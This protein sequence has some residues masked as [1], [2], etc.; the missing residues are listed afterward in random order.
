MGAGVGGAREQHAADTMAGDWEHKAVVVGGGEAEGG[1]G[2]GEDQQGAPKHGG[3]AADAG[4]DAVRLAPLFEPL[5]RA[6][7]GGAVPAGAAGGAN[8]AITDLELVKR[9]KERA[10]AL[11]NVYEAE[12]WSLMELLRAEHSR[13]V[14]ESGKTGLASA[15]DGDEAAMAAVVAAAEAAAEAGGGGAV[16][17]QDE[18]REYSRRRRQLIAE[19]RDAQEPGTSGAAAENG[20]QD[21]TKEGATV[22]E[23]ETEKPEGAPQSGGG[24]EADG[25]EREDDDDCG[26]IV[27]FAEVEKMILLGAH[28]RQQVPEDA[29]AANGGSPAPLGERARASPSVLSLGWCDSEATRRRLREAL[30]RAEMATESASVRAAKGALAVILG[31]NRTFPIHDKEVTIGRGTRDSRCDVDLALEDSELAAKLSRHAAVLTYDSKVDQHFLANT[32]R[33]PIFVNGEE[34]AIGARRAL[35]RGCLLELARIPCLF[36][37][38][39]QAARVVQGREA[40][41]AAK[42][43]VSGRGY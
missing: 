19:R 3:G 27:S 41:E 24:Q 42:R 28:A 33:R 20:V 30:L 32:G 16:S 11:C 6:R 35:P 4:L 37:A 26:G 9:R 23:A 1:T 2:G 22:S 13:F 38:H 7:A 8:G 34:L 39:P 5:E 12:Y 36:V 18:F 29:P 25:D 14:A 17:V 40:R 21:A 43:A 10:E 15:A 31:A